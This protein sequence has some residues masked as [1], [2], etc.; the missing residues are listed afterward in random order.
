VNNRLREYR[1]MT[2]MSLAELARRAKTSRQTITKIEKEGR[3]TNSFIMLRICDVLKV[4]DPR[5]IFFGYVGSRENGG[6][7]A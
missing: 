4:S 5:I 2:G 1:K 3:V 6:R 7:S